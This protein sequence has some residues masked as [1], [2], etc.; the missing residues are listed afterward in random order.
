[1]ESNPKKTL[2]GAVSVVKFDEIEA[3]TVTTISH[4]LAGKAAGLRVNQ[5]SAQPGGGSKFRIR[6][7]RVCQCQQ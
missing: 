4:A 3:P 1:M 7:G 6:G 5:Q 2:T